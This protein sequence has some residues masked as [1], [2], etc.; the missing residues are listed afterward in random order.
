QG[1]DSQGRARCR[2][3]GHRQVYRFDDKPVADTKSLIRRLQAELI[4]AASQTLV[5]MS[6]PIKTG[7]VGAGSGDG[8]RDGTRNE[9]GWD[10]GRA[11][12]PA[13]LFDEVRI[14]RRTLLGLVTRLRSGRAAA[15]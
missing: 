6:Q 5:E 13:G 11:V 7:K 2:V 14:H 3:D 8:R 9:R 4:A 12:V 10:S 15:N 1:G